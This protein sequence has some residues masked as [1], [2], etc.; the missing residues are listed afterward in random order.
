MFGS[1]CIAQELDSHYEA[2]CT[3]VVAVICCDGRKA[4]SQTWGWDGM[5]QYLPFFWDEHPHPEVAPGF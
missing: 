3:V 5:G 4:I 2:C 1:E